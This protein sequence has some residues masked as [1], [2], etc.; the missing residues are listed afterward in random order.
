[1]CVCATDKL[2]PTLGQGTH[3]T[4]TLPLLNVSRWS[5]NP[6]YRLSAFTLKAWFNVLEKKKGDLV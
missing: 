6:V 2:S 3:D 5:F 4:I 1:M